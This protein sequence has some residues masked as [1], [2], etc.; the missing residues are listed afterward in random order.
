MNGPVAMSFFA[1]SDDNMFQHENGDAPAASQV[2]LTAALGRRPYSVPSGRV[3]GLG[4]AVDSCLIQLMFLD[5]NDVK[6]HGAKENNRFFG[7]S[8]IGREHF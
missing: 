5:H 3:T 7:A 6:T 8:Y 2:M 4:N 1:L